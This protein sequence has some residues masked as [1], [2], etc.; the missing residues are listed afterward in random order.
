MTPFQQLY[1]GLGAKKKTYMDDVFSTYL[2][3]GTGSTKTINN[4]IDMSEGGMTWIKDRDAVNEA[5]IFDTER[6]VTK[7]L[8]PSD[9]YS[10]ATQ[11]SNSLTSFNNNGFTIGGWSNVNT[12]SRSIASF[13]FRKAKGFFDVVTYTGNETNRTISHS[14]GCIPGMIIIKRR[15]A[16]EDWMVYH[17]ANADDTNNAGH[18]HLKLNDNSAYTNS[19]T[20][21]NDT[22]PTASVFFCW[23]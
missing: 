4:G 20:K 18:Y 23:Y 21:F 1:L 6:G 7:Y 10:E 2:Y 3:S 16:A 17:K 19:A 13:T 15:D 12:S 8:I 9:N 22:E 14:L 11:S 5:V